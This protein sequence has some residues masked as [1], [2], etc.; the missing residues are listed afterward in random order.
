M[1]SASIYINRV[2]KLS[3][4]LIIQLSPQNIVYSLISAT[5]CS[6]SCG[7]MLGANR[8]LVTESLPQDVAH[9]N[10]VPSI[11]SLRG[12]NCSLFPWDVEFSSSN[13]TARRKCL[14]FRGLEQAAAKIYINGA[15]N[16]CFFRILSNLSPIF[17][18]INTPD[19][20]SFTNKY[21]YSLCQTHFLAKN[22][23]LSLF[24]HVKLKDL[25]FFLLIFEDFVQISHLFY[26]MILLFN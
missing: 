17:F 25:L 11:A 8:M 6:L 16:T 21:A 12:L 22:K 4:V 24:I 23:F 15:K 26:I 9:Y 20:L 19:K 5:A 14:H 7:R 13:H 3:G 2:N 1:I 10:S 18:L